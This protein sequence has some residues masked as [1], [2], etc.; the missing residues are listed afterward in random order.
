MYLE[1]KKQGKGKYEW[2]DGSYFDGDWDDNKI[3]GFGTYYWADG[4]GYT[5]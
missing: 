2:P 5:G 1:G 4:R 3:T